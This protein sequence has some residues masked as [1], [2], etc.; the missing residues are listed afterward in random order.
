VA[1][2]T[3]ARPALN[4]DARVRHHAPRVA[5]IGF[6]GAIG[7]LVVVPLVRLQKLAFE[8]NAHGYRRAFTSPHIAETIRMTVGLAL[9]SLV[10]AL[11]L[12]T[13][14]AWCATR[15]PPRLG[16]LRLLPILPIVLP[17][18]ANVVGW[19]F[20]LSP[21]PGYLNALLRRLPWWSH[22]DAGPVDVYTKPWIIIIT[23]FALTSFVYLFVSA[24]LRNIN[25]ELLEAAQVSGSSSVGV[26]LKV[27]LPLLR[28]VLVYGGGVALLLGLGQFTGPLLLG[29]NS[30]ISTL[31]TQM[32]FAASNSPVDY[33]AAAAFGS[34]LLL[35]GLSVVI[36]QKVI[37]G[38]HSRFVTH[39]G[40]VFRSTARPSKLAAAT[41]TLYTTVAI[42][43][44][45][46]ALFIVA[47]SKFWSGDIKVGQFSLE[48]FRTIF[49]QSGITHA[50]S[51][52]ISASLIAV[53]ISLP[54][55]FLAATVLLRGRRFGVLRSMLDFVVA[56]PLGIPAVLFGVGFL[57]TYTHKPFVLYGTKWVIILVYVTLM[58]PFTTRMQLSGMVALGDQYVEASRVSGAGVVRTNIKVIVPLMRS[59]LGGAA[60]LMFVLL[61]HEFAASLL[62]RSP[63]TQVMG[64]VL[65]DYYGNGSYPLVA[66]IALIMAL[67]TTIGVALAMAIGGTDAL[68][69]L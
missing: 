64:T 46:I 18:V 20:L 26:F 50:I 15:L 61:T 42:V 10:I 8:N 58:L 68:S 49:H 40:R 24:G 60:A 48:N 1:V 4:W 56:M 19:S 32:Y 5:L 11:V 55:G 43:L 7:Y 13:G 17:A 65:F 51:T 30:G 67:V 36:L 3:R 9:G 28:P 66:C 57:L 38:D 29:T 35:F 16:F 33:A 22:L 14:L 62:V 27:T 44:P 12:G 53:A 63:T 45:V 54:V 69:K 52:S 25:S 31:T 47:L 23:G 41:I 37:L 2:V 21:R 34:P 6:I 39:S 59:T